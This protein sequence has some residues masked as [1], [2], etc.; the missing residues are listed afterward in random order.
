VVGKARRNLVG[1]CKLEPIESR[2]ECVLF[3]RLKL[4]CVKLLSNVAFR[5]KLRHYNLATMDLMVFPE[6]CLHGQGRPH[7]TF[8]SPQNPNP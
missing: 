2:V 8:F 7:I 4:T 6:Y 5:F 3:Q 1:W